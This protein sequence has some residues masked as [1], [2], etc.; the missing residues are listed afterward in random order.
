VHVRVNSLSLLVNVMPH[1][2][3]L[4]KFNELSESLR[5]IASPV[6]ALVGCIISPESPKSGESVGGYMSTPGKAR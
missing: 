2:L 4:S 1:R 3:A 6:Q 5:R